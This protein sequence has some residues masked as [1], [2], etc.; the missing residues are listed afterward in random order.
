MC[1]CVFVSFKQLEK[2]HS[3]NP[4]LCLPQL[5]ALEQ[6]V[7]QAKSFFILIL[8]KNQTALKQQIKYKIK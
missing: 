2:F 3:I 4:S 6:P 1:T 5:F 7:M 8:K